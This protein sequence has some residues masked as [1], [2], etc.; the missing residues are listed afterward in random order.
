MLNHV[1]GQVW[2][3]WYFIYSFAGKT[4]TWTLTPLSHWSLRNPCRFSQ[5]LCKTQQVAI[6]LQEFSFK[7][8]LL[9]ILLNLPF[10]RP[11]AFSTTSLVVLCL[12]LKL[13]SSQV[14]LPRSVYGFMSHLLRAKA[15]SPNIRGGTRA[16]DIITYMLGWTKVRAQHRANSGK[17]LKTCASCTLPSHPTQINQ[18]Q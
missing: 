12:I 7:S 18:K 10:N 16:P 2:M 15:K 8:S 13:L 17:F 4:P 6:T 5:Y 9:L 1:Q 3:I 11:K 14:K